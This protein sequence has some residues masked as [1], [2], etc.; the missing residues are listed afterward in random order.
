MR[1]IVIGDPHGNYNGILSLL[2]KTEY[3][4]KKD[5]LVFTGDYIDHF[6]DIGGN[7]NKTISLILSLKEESDKVFTVIGNHDYWMYKW[8]ISRTQIPESVWYEQG[9]RET[10]KS[11]NSKYALPYI[12][13][14]ETKKIP[15]EHVD[16]ICSLDIFYMDE[17]I[18]VIHGGFDSIGSM[19]A[20]ANNY[21][22]IG[23]LDEFLDIIWDRM[24]CEAKFMTHNDAILNE[25]YKRLFGDRLCIMGHTPRGPFINW[26]RNKILIDGGSKGGGKLL[27]VIIEENGE[28]S[29]EEE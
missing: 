4:P 18:L 7:V 21:V 9:G 23:N 6:P 28:L 13:F 27:A 10:L 12:S 25:E 24:F 8:I 15:K 11:Y 14:E 2:K 17:K 1:R 5:I 22:N 26:K 19:R 16:F 29:I 3:T 20:I